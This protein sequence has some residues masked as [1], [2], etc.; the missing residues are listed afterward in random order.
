[1]DE[2]IRKRHPGYDPATM[3]HPTDLN[4]T[5]VRMYFASGLH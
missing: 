2:V 3:K 5:K 4:W 1:M